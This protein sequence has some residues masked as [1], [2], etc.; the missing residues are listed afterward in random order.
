ML[1]VSANIYRSA[2]DHE[3]GEACFTPF[4][5]TLSISKQINQAQVTD[6][7]AYQE[8]LLINAHHNAQIIQ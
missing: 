6:Q 2:A 5:V 1:S 7:E 4:D 8:I 3:N